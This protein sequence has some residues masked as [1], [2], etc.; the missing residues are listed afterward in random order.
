MCLKRLQQAP[1]SI[2]PPG[3]FVEEDGLTVLYIYEIQFVPEARRKGLGTWIMA[4]ME[5]LAAAVG[6]R[7]IMLTVHKSNGPAIRFYSQLGFKAREERTDWVTSWNRK[8]SYEILF[9]GLQEDA[10]SPGV[11]NPQG[12]CDYMILSKYFVGEPVTPL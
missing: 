11:S 5:Q 3:R 1:S 10:T 4:V 8:Q 9:L 2:R 7:G 12:K 6:M